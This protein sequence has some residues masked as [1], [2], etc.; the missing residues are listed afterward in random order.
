MKDDFVIDENIVINAW[1]GTNA[2]NERSYSEKS[3]LNFFIPSSKKLL[4]TINI[5][6]KYRKLTHTT[7]KDTR[8][9]DVG[10][11]KWFLERLL[12]SE[13]CP[14]VEG[15][16]IPNYKHIKDDDAEFVYLAITKDGHLVTVD[17]RMWDEIKDEIKDDNLDPKIKY[18]N[19]KDAISLVSP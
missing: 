11:K 4:I 13:K 14:I 3:F 8:N 10:V 5:L 15:L 2:K 17:K 1:R 19:V 9:E 7:L 6:A 18:V 16:K 12:D